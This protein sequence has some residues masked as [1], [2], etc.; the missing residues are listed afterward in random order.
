VI[1]TDELWGG[2]LVAVTFDPV[3]W[4][5]SLGVEVLSS[6]ESRR[7]ALTLDGV[8]QWRSSR[9]VPLP[10]SYAELTEIHVSDAEG[11]KLVEL[12]LWADDTVLTA[13]CARVRLDRLE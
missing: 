4:T 6:G 13:R 11:Q 2:M 7:Y 10:W 3:A 8:D 12:V 9:S 1:E 5:L